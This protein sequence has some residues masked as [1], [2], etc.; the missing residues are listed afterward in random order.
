MVLIP[1]AQPGWL[2]GALCPRRN[3]YRQLQANPQAQKP[4]VRIPSPP[5][6][7]RHHTV[8]SPPQRPE[9]SRPIHGPPVEIRPYAPPVPIPLVAIPP[10]IAAQPVMPVAVRFGVTGPHRQKVPPNWAGPVKT[11]ANTNVPCRQGLQRS[12]RQMGQS[13]AETDCAVF[14]RPRGH[15]THLAHLLRSRAAALLTDNCYPMLQLNFVAAMGPDHLHAPT[16][17]PTCTAV[18]VT[19][20]PN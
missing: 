7:G 8:I 20:W 15:A 1:V 10:V 13:T 17:G 6:P 3:D 2:K 14:T 12:Y 9:T 16:R 19:P 11:A 4:I 18:A 5:V